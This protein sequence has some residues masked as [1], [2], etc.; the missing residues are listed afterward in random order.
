MKKTL[1]A[2]FISITLSAN[3]TTYY[4][5]PNGSD[6]T[7]NGSISTPWKTLSYAC[8]RVT[9]S[10]D[11]IHINA[12]TYTVS[13]QCTLAVGVSI[14]GDGETSQITSSIT[15]E[16]S[17]TIWLSSG[18]E[19]TNGNQ[20]ISYIKMSGG[21]TAF[22]AIG[23]NGRSNVKI[24]NCWF[25][26]FFAQGVMFNG[27]TGYLNHAPGIFATGNEFHDNIVTNCARYVSENNN[28]DGCVM[29]G[30]QNGLLI[31]N[32]TIV[33][34]ARAAGLNGYCL[35]Y[36]SEGYN[37][38]VK[39]YNN[40]LTTAPAAGQEPVNSWGF[41]IESHNSVGG[42]EF[43][44]NTCKGA[45]DLVNSSQ[46][47]FAFAW[48]I[49]DNTIGFD[50]QS[51]ALDSEGDVGI[52]FELNFEKTNIYRNHFKNLAMAIYVSC[53][54]GYTMKDLYVYTNLFENLG[55]T[56]N[57]KGW[58]VRFIPSPLNDLTNTVT[59]WN[60]WNNVIVA[61]TAHT[62]AY[63]IQLPYGNA[64]NF[65]VR[66]NI[67][68][69]FTQGPVQ[70]NNVGTASNVS[71]EN[72]IF[73]K[74]GNNND[75]YGTSTYTNYTYQNN[76]KVD[77]LFVSSSDFHL[78][79]SS[80]AIN[81]G[82]N[83]GLTNDY[84]GNQWED[85]PSIGAYESGSGST[86][87]VSPVYQ[88]SVIENASPSIITITYDLTLANIVPAPS[89]FNVQVNSVG[90][91][92]NSVAIAGGK[93]QL[94]LASPVIA[95]DVVT[96]S[97]VKPASNPIQTASGGLAATISNKS[98][99][100]NCLATVPIYQSSVIENAT[101]TI[102]EMTYD[103]SLA[104]IVPATSAFNV[105]VNSVRRT[106]ISVAIVNGKVRLAL[107]SAVIFSDVVTVA[108]VQPATNPLQTA[109]GGVAASISAK[110]VTNKCTLQVPVYVGSVIED[111]TP[112]L[113]EIS[114]DI[115]L[116]NVVP[117][118]SSF[119]VQVNSVGRTVSSVAIVGGKVRLTLATKVV[120]G[121][122]VT[123][124]YT[125]PSSNPLQTEAGGMAASFS[126][127]SVTNNCV[128]PIPVYVG[129]VIENTTPS[130]IEISYD[131][132][133]A[134]ILPSASAFNVQVNTVA[135]TVSSV[136]IVSG[137][138]RLTLAS[139]VVSGDIVT[140]SYTKPSSNPLQTDAGGV[141]A[142]ISSKTVTNN[143]SA[144]I[145]VYTGSV[146]ENATPSLLEMSFDLSL[147]NIVPA[148]SAF[149]VQVNS[150]A[151]TVSSVAIVT[152]KVRLTLAS[153]VVYGDLVTIAYN[154]P[155]SNP[156][157]TA[158]GGTAAS[159]STK[160]VTN[161]CVLPV[162]VYTGSVIENAAPA[163]IL[164]SYDLS[165]ANIVPAPSAFSVQVNSVARAVSSVAIVS[166]KVQLTL[167]SAVVFGDIVTVSYSK[168]STNPLRTAAGGEAASINAKTVTNNCAAPIPVYVG[169]VIENASPGI[170]EISYDLSLANIVPASSAFTVQVNSVD[171]TVASVAIAG[172]KVRLTLSSVVVFGDIVTVAYTRPASNPLQ[173]ASG[174]V[175]ASI[176]NKSVTNN[177][178]SPIPVYIGAVIENE[179]PGIIVISYDLSLANIVPPTSA[180]N[181]QVNS[182]RRT[183][184]S[185]AIVGGK[186]RLTLSS[187]VSF[188]DMV[189]V[190]YTKPSVNPLQTASGGVAASTST[191]KSVTNNIASPP[192]Y[193]SSVIENATPSILTISF[194]SSLANIVPATSSFYILVN[195]VARTINSIVISGVN[196]QLTLA[197]PVV[198][199]DVITFTYT[200]PSN[201]PLQTTSG[202][203]AA[204]ISSK[205]VTNNCVSPAIYV[206]S[207]VE[208]ATPAIL[209]MTYNQN[210]ASIVPAASSFYVLVNSVAR[211]VNSV[212]IAG[213]DVQLT[214]ASPVI[215]GDIITVAYTKP[216]SN[217][218]QTTSGGLAASITAKS[219][220][221]NCVSPP[222]FVSA[223]ID[224]ATP[225]ILS[226]T[227][228]PVLTNIVP[229]TSSFY[230]LV[231]SVARTV[232]SVAIVG[233]AVQLTLA[234]SVVFGDIVTVA[235]NKP[236]S[237]PLQTASGGVAASM[238]AKPVTNNCVSPPVYVSSVIENA[239][240]ALLIMTYNQNLASTVPASSSFYVLVNSVARTI[241]SVAVT[242]SN[243]QLTLAT[244]VVFGDVITVAYTKPSNNPLQTASGGVA[245][246]INAKPVTN[247][248][249]APPVYIS[250]AIENV[251]PNLLNITYDQSLANIVPA[252]S[253]FY[254]LV[255]SVARTIS[256]VAIAGSNVQLTLTSPV[257]FGDVISV[258]YTKPVNNQLQTPSGGIAASI[259]AK[260]VTNN[261]VAPPV[262]VSSV[263][264]NAAP[265]LLTITFNISLTNIVPAKTAFYVLV[266]SVARTINS[267]AISNGNVQLT[268]ASQVVYGDIITVAYTKPANNPLQTASGGVAANFTAKSVTNN[269]TPPT[270]VYVSSVIENVTPSVLE[271]TYDISLANIVPSVSSFSVRVNSMTRVV[272]SVSIVGNK[273]QL[274]LASPVTYGD[275]ITVSYTR[276]SINP[277]QTSL[278]VTASSFRSKS[279]TNNCISSIPVYVSSVIKNA[280]PDII[281]MTYS[282][283]LANIVPGVAAF[284]VQVNSIE[285]NVSSVAIVGGKV[286]LTLASPVVF[287]DIVTVSYTVPANN[288]L[289]TYSGGKATSIINQSV[290]NDCGIIIPNY[291]SS[292]VDNATP[293]I[294]EMTYDL[295]LANIIPP[296]SAFYVL[297]NAVSVTVDSVNII[298]E[299]VLL[300]LHD[301]I[302]YGDLVTVSYTNPLINPLQSI[303]G[304]VAENISDQA[305]KNNCSP[306]VPVFVGAQI[307]NVAPSLLVIT[308]N[309]DLADI[310]PA[311]SAFNVEVNL[312]P[313]KVNS[314]AIVG[315]KVQL[316]LS[317]AIVFGDIVT[318]D[319]ISPATNPLQTFS[320]G[321]AAS[322]NGES[323]TNNCLATI[324]SY[325]NSVVE[326]SSATILDMTYDL[327]LANIVPA[328]SAF[329]VQVNS[330]PRT[331]NSV[332]IAG[333]N[334]LLTLSST[335]V[336]GDIINVSYTRPATNPLQTT[337]GGQAI[338]IF[339]QSV[340]NNCDATI[341]NYINSVV[342]N[343]SAN[344]VEMIYD[345]D[346][347]DIVPAASA[348]DVQVN[349]ESRVVNLVSITGH[350]V[351]LTLSGAIV[352]GDIVTVSYSSPAVNPLQTASGGLADSI[353]NQ[354]VTNNCAGNIPNYIN[355][356]VENI[357]ATVVDITYDQ[358]LANIVPATSAFD[359]QVNSVSITI[360]S[361]EILGEKVRLTLASAVFIGDVV[362]V[363]YTSPAINPLQTPAGGLAASLSKQA[364]TNNCVEII[365]NYINSV[366]ENASSTIVDIAYDSDLANIIPAVSAFDV[367]VNSVSRDVISVSILGDTV[368]LTLS[369]A[370]DFGDIV[371]VSYSSPAVNPLQTPSG[372]LAVSI[373]NQ[374][375]TNNCATTIPSY[376]S[377]VVE[378]VAPTQLDMIYNLD[379][380]DII[381]DTSAFDVQ[382][383]SVPV[384]VSAVEILGE[385]V[386]LT[387]SEA[388]VFG[389][390]VTVNYTRPAK[391]PLQT[392][393]GEMAES[394]FN[395]SVTNNCLD[396][397]VHND[398]PV[399]EFESVA[400]GYSGF[401]YEL[402]ASGSYDINNDSLY[403][404]WISKDG[405]PISSASSS[406]IRFLAP[407]VSNPQVLEFQLNIT[408]GK[409]IKTGSFT[410]NILPYKPEITRASIINI[411]ASNYQ[412][413]D[414]PNN[415]KD[416]NL[417]TKWS[418][419]GDNQWIVFTLDKI[420]KLS[421]FEIAFLQEQKYESYFDI[422]ASI[423]NIKWDPIL[424]N[425][426]SCN[427]SGNFQVFD[428]PSSFANNKYKYV[429]LVGHGNIL[430][431]WNNISEFRIFGSV[432]SDP[433]AVGTDLRK[434]IIYPN[435]AQ[436]YFN[437]SIEE[438]T[439]EP[440]LILII[441]NS[442]K[443]VLEEPFKINVNRVQIPDN[444]NSG[445]YYVELR[446]GNIILDAQKLIINR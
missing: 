321:T 57:G 47:T 63:G 94:T 210:L 399:L 76:L 251:T 408:D 197:S 372:G 331:V 21:S 29:F 102:L 370:V 329:D 369:S 225:A 104:N 109:S 112:S 33:Q 220:T 73:Y 260:P 145:P 327:A 114:Y 314:V 128:L 438:P 409:A 340:T 201:N 426:A 9:K 81:K 253:S 237:N 288:P 404:E 373:N 115:S 95:G 35:K 226:M 53:T 132:S 191:S 43:Y 313:R 233:G 309:L 6:A 276:P 350:T 430:N 354:S 31:Y 59:N 151:R 291:I 232:N 325:V 392:L 148:T 167:A 304:G 87:P 207:V 280:T 356:I 361:I 411:K 439:M 4:I 41:I 192:V 118:A 56:L 121:D 315:G 127:K 366:V 156:L 5:S 28:G 108:Y 155:V 71:I 355:S 193:V 174:G 437:I 445:I 84:D 413:P 262:Y 144:S 126:T 183:I 15:T 249:V 301:P 64:S 106:V 299:K 65:S 34:T 139:A 92:V 105:Q 264:E 406:K 135:R 446:S 125:K 412:V 346:L 184:T 330:K 319:Y 77:P 345:L 178:I 119:T 120:Y 154:K 200:K 189:T 382:V 181:V 434:T 431:T 250:A 334:V 388:V 169:S 418:V 416:D 248:C 275:R 305:V 216:V 360:S 425:S 131:L 213:S 10:G 66:N 297:V 290:T 359:V 333:N 171:R 318:L 14:E 196:V 96:I 50:T 198:F 363:S 308:Y 371:T 2:L 212:A 85:P 310:V 292:V 26:D 357:S 143:C 267:V 182:V 93:I 284:Y 117:A 402:D 343:A 422:Y 396:R 38:G 39:I 443:V 40:I 415:S 265:A 27:G 61:G 177:C 165:L 316:T 161:N 244:P 287:G 141:A 229:V 158:S 160:T 206:S 162:P 18:S 133:L 99:I 383:N 377:S 311:V 296:S 414:Y 221:N 384:T 199:G 37:K 90:R 140:V 269:C 403:F 432:Q 91:T 89:A 211:T 421:Y 82:L 243:V 11:I 32:N 208:N 30:G 136:A 307:D 259:S 97:Y 420:F 176:S 375:V 278:G 110:S 194:N 407:V 342:E 436:S 235:Y 1:L 272:N 380:A 263:I 25:E 332:S 224:N 227:Y 282:L 270:P 60:I 273:V 424:T 349:S 274:I 368:H 146:V 202:G 230:V 410:V 186:V 67:I 163:M 339:S 285:R 195:S 252:P 302:V 347:A 62:T 401:I 185:V 134:N 17:N 55:T 164:M 351:R 387:L 390:I 381:P 12:G 257:V 24:Y 389:D 295:N 440:D 48:D 187:A 328:V 204:S 129:S 393:T 78:Q 209:K 379:L 398:P 277:L 80:T 286:Q 180:F 36:Y 170:L 13:S 300:T 298:G 427:F 338:S 283:S 231:N 83:V 98:V 256:S 352:Y 336:F 217:P 435:P 69:G 58:A 147:A 49:H 385:R 344:I 46:G 72:N 362:T 405:V 23:V 218:L 317:D 8:G 245:A 219:V 419:N 367:Q 70:K 116:A 175:A 22:G 289:Q 42:M 159:I 254:I 324:P 203:I 240:P 45:L 74:N 166:G 391:N 442:G 79:S 364:V 266:N 86:T 88:S 20:H 238:G 353:I 52:R 54:A 417:A 111:A 19:G 113:L 395:Q 138:V 223:K 107:A 152:G 149:I 179:N 101:P 312:V 242:G 386:R 130:I 255:N 429:K 157:Q 222:V 68:V 341:P 423:D 268:L 306:V 188:G 376:T 75:P 172:G 16:F 322:I 444:I 394:I 323:V 281:E 103:L 214:L 228:N 261:C 378:D 142:S 335:V 239:T 326:G 51:P 374:S 428:L 150:T 433:T 153:N 247:N 358:D 205:S 279:V 271:M 234:S 190:T 100:N 236:S 7:G 123:I 168:P 137:K 215:F 303:D 365:P 3:A 397:S 258:S 400:E 124:A 348:F 241:N 294:L 173:T 122:Q 44:G 246:S 320:G 441:D 293:D 337:S